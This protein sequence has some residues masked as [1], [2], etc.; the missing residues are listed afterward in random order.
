MNEQLT[1]E[2]VADKLR[3][4]LKEEKITYVEMQRRLESVGYALSTPAVRNYFIGDRTIPMDV[5]IA[6][7]KIINLPKPEPKPKCNYNLTDFG[8]IV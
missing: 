6:I 5:F 3:G 2:E 4:I 1:K 7:L 8:Y